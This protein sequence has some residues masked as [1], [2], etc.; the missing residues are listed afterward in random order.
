M[1]FPIPTPEEYDSAYLHNELESIY[2]ELLALRRFT[3]SVGTSNNQSYV[4]DDYITSG[5]AVAGGVSPPALTTF[6]GNIKLYAFTGTGPT[7]KD[8]YATTHILHGIRPGSDINLHVHYSTNTTA[9]ASSKVIWNVEWTLAR[10]YGLGTFGDPA[11]PSTSCG[12]MSVTSTVSV[13][14]FVHHITSDAAMTIPTNAE[15]TPDSV[16][17]LRLYRDPTH[18]A[19]TFDGN[20]FLIQVD[21]HYQRDRV[22]TTER[23][24]PFGSWR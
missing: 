18:V 19:D 23:N 15:M 11:V 9:T 22:G 14:P 16:F 13:A 4:W 8:V 12:T 21:F 6:I 17:L 1:Y 7:A 3:G 24:A 2:E 10:G 20:A 5:L